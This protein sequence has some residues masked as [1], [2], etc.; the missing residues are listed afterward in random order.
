MRDSVENPAV[1]KASGRG[2][3]VTNEIMWSVKGGRAECS[4]NGKLIAGY[5]QAQIVG[6]GKLESTNGTFG[7]RVSHNVDVSVAGFGLVK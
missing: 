6:A 4:V 3:S 5:D 1:N 2:G 7:I